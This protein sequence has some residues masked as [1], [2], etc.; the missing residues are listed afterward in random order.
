M[1]QTLKPVMAISDA[2]RAGR[3]GVHR[4][5]PAWKPMRWPMTCTD[6]R[7]FA[8][9]ESGHIKKGKETMRR[10]SM[11]GDDVFVAGRVRTRENLQRF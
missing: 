7:T 11:A 6:Q 5:S 3:H 2:G 8:G 1:T 9:D 4:G 10:D